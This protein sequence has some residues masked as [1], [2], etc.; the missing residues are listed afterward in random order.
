LAIG[1]APAKRGSVRRSGA[2]RQPG[3]H[4]QTKPTKKTKHMA[5]VTLSRSEIE[6][7]VVNNATKHLC[8][9]N[10]DTDC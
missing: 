4:N 5:S 2:F 6:E 3:E 10:I 7:L 8:S 1:T 9:T